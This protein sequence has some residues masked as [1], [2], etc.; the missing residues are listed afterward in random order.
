MLQNY[1]YDLLDD[2]EKNTYDTM[3]S[4]LSAYD[5]K[6]AVFCNDGDSVNRV[7]KAVVFDNPG[8]VG[9]H[10]IMWGAPQ[11]RGGMYELNFEYADFDA[12]KYDAAFG[13]ATDALS[14]V[15]RDTDDD[16]AVCKKIYEYVTENVKYAHEV[17]NRYFFLKSHNRPQSEMTQFLREKSSAF[18]AYGAFVD[19]MATCEGISKAFMLLCEHFGVQCTVVGAVTNDGGKDPHMFNVVEL[20]GVRAYV[21]CTAGL[22]TD[23]WD[24]VRYDYF[25][26]PERLMTKHYELDHSFEATAEGL[27][28]FSRNGRRFTDVYALRTYLSAYSIPSSGREVRVFYDGSKLSD[29]E[30]RTMFSEIINNGCDKFNSMRGCVVSDGFCNGVITDSEED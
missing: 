4:A 15:I 1:Y 29:G 19:R 25:A 5:A 6:C 27:D 11:S 7:H 30:L 21:D 26:V 3:R 12:G 18:T 20:D 8:I 9:Y 2:G 22:K 24:M 10:G 14:R 13:K 16:Y 28:Y 23:G 17:L